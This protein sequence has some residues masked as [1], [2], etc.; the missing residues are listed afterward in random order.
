MQKRM[1]S[2]KLHTNAREL[3]SQTCGSDLCYVT[4][5]SLYGFLHASKLLCVKIWGE[6]PTL[7]S[8]KSGN[9]FLS[10][11]LSLGS[12]TERKFFSI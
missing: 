10:A 8:E 9:F 2:V 3:C 12:E 6:N 11:E 1:H 4:Y 5:A 7:L